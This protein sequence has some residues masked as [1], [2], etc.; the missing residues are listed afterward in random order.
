MTIKRGLAFHCHHDILVE[1]VHDYDERVKFIKTSK[2]K[3]E[4][5]LRLRLFQLIPDEKVLGK[6]SPQGEAYYKAR[7]AY[8]KVE[9]A[10]YKAWEAYYKARVAYNKARVVYN[11]AWEAYYKV[12]EAYYKAWVAYDKATEAYL[13]KYQGEIEKLHKELC[14]DCPWNGKSIFKEVIT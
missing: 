12:E 5:S 9:E 2:P 6:D 11:K 14:P 1:Y 7:E 3:K 13:E 10:Y 4:Q 8:Y